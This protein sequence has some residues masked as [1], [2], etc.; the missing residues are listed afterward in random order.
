M[1]LLEA[2]IGLALVVTVCYAVSYHSI[3]LV[4]DETRPE[5]PMRSVLALTIGDALIVRWVTARA[6]PATTASA[7]M[8]LNPN[9][10]FVITADGNRPLALVAN[11]L[12]W[13]LAWWRLLTAGADDPVRVAACAGSALRANGSGSSAFL[14][15][16]VRD[17]A[18]LDALLGR[19]PGARLLAEVSFDDHRVVTLATALH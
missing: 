6:E 10:R 16:A 18:C 17:E 9:L 5:G 14:A 13:R 15:V 1:P 19:Y 3:G 11:S 12:R 7:Q 2:L 4:V 8:Q